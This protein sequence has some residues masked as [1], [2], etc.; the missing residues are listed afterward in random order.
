MLSFQNHRT[1]R[2]SLLVY[3]SSWAINNLSFCPRHESSARL[4]HSR[5]SRVFPCELVRFFR[6]KLSLGPCWSHRGPVS[7]PGP[8]DS[9]AFP[10]SIA[11]AGEGERFLCQLW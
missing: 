3:S 5:H 11:L 4:C 1:W 6:E 2:L 7:T 9:S 8:W 10:P